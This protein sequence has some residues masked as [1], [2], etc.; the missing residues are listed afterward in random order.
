MN[1]TTARLFCFYNSEY[2]DYEISYDCLEIDSLLFLTDLI[3]R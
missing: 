3:R 1:R 2:D